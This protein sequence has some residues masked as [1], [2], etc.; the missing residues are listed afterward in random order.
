MG[1]NQSISGSINRKYPQ[2]PIVSVHVIIIKGNKVLLVKRAQ[3]PSQGRWSIPG[4]VIELGES[5]NE[6]ARRE[7]LEE[8]G[9]KIEIGKVLN[10]GENVIHDG[11]GLV[12][13]HY[14]LIFKLA[15]YVSGEIHPGSDA[16]E[17]RW[18]TYE[19]LDPLDMHP[20]A[21]KT[22]QQVFETKDH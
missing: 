6:A 22:I 16:A 21:R 5:V 7:V 3:P 17:V 2:H 8:C 12:Q 13:F 4:G 9:I 11:K 1:N 15:N 14:I 18:T 20:V 10:I 19:E